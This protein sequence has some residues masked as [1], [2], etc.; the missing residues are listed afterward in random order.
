MKFHLQRERTAILLAV[1]ITFTLSGCAGKKVCYAP[2][3]KKNYQCQDAS[4]KEISFEEQMAQFYDNWEGVP[5]RLGEDGRHGLDCS[6]FIQKAACRLLG[7]NLPRTVVEMVRCGEKI[8]REELQPGDLVFFRT[9]WKNRHVGMYLGNSHF[10]H[11][12]SSKGVSISSLD[13]E[14]DDSSYWS[15]KYW[16]AR[17]IL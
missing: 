14:E 2:P 1:V 11:V 12:S 6:A 16:C 10:M 9:G 17:R 13:P 7:V 3:Q 15:S 4:G 5:W 8:R